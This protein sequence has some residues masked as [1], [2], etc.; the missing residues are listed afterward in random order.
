M[1]QWTRACGRARRINKADVGQQY[2]VCLIVPYKFCLIRFGF[3]AAISS[4][5][6][7][8]VTLSVRAC[9][10]SLVWNFIF[11]FSKTK[12]W[13]FKTPHN[14]INYILTIFLSPPTPS[15]LPYPSLPYYPNVIDKNRTFFKTSPS[16]DREAAMDRYILWLYW[17]Y[18]FNVIN[19][20][21][22]GLKAP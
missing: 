19:K 11:L 21:V 16:W 7:D 5:R 6:S 1:S 8:I 4:S 18:R 13:S 10:R 22:G 15:Y 2:Y 14:L 20:V 9:I 12:L 3:L 17:L